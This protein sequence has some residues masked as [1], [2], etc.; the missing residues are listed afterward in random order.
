MESA[1][2]TSSVRSEVRVVT[3]PTPEPSKDKPKE[4]P[5]KKPSAKKSLTS[6]LVPSTSSN[7][8][9]FQQ[10]KQKKSSVKPESKSKELTLVVPPISTSLS[11]PILEYLSRDRDLIS[12]MGASLPPRQEAPLDI[13]RSPTAS[14]LVQAIAGIANAPHS[15]VLTRQASRSQS[16]T[17][18]SLSSA[19]IYTSKET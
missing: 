8:P 2:S 4:K 15:P 1:P 12:E 19:S 9:I 6:T 13:E 11:S 14:Q 3:S 18:G 10:L 17:L 16:L 5:K 7:P